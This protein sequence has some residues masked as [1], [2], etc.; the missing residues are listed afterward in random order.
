MTAGFA[1]TGPAGGP[2]AE[3]VAPQPPRIE[4]PTAGWPAPG[5]STGA[6]PPVPP[7]PVA[8]G[9]AR[10]R[11]S[12][13]LIVLVVLLGVLVVAQAAFLVLVEGQLADAN[14]KI[15]GLAGTQDKR[16]HDVTGRVQTLE[17][18]AAKTLDV[19]AVTQAVLPSVFKITVPDGTATAFAI[20]TTS[21]GT[22]LLT[23]Y[24]VVETL[25]NQG[26]RTA[27]IN[28]DNQRFPVT[29]VRVDPDN[30]L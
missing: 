20:G 26:Q 14:R 1:D 17:Q 9:T 25:W 30:D 29:V 23:N 18:Q 10:T 11:R 24:H 21:S 27:E 6:F 8:P 3:R 7:G 13:L 12:P 4:P 15:D 16:L 2:D 5:Y 22:D 19:Q 28:H